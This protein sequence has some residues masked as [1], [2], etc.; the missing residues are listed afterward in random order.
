MSNLQKI[1]DLAVSV[2]SSLANLTIQP[3][4]LDD[5]DT[6]TQQR[7]ALR[8]KL[9]LLN[10]VEAAEAERLEDERIAAKVEQRRN[11]LKE[12]CEQSKKL[13]SEYQQ[14]TDNVIKSADQLVAALA[15]REQ[16]FNSEL[17]QLSN[18]LISELLTLEERQKL[19][20][21]FDR[22]I[23]NIHPDQF[24][25]LWKNSVSTHCGD[26]STLSNRLFTLVNP[27]QN[28]VFELT[29]A[30]S[31]LTDTAHY[32][33]EHIA[34]S[35]KEESE[36]PQNKPTGSRYEVNLRDGSKVVNLNA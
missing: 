21:E 14:H 35:V 6:I 29:G 26:N 12:I 11:L 24:S 4:N 2:K 20:N 23:I 3:D 27:I 16:V 17:L 33:I 8:E 15:Q 1:K 7:V 36:V 32:M 9:N 22:T 19:I 18:P 13:E 30:N 5:I 25:T 31:F 34:L 10:D 28:R